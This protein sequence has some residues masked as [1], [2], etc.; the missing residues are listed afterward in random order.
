M[1][2]QEIK[3]TAEPEAIEAVSDV[4]YQLGS[5]G[6]VIED[7]ELL[8]KMASSGLWDACELS[9]D[10]FCQACPVVK[11]YFP[12]N[13]KLPAKIEE[14]KREITEIAARLGQK[15]GELTVAVVREEDWANSWKAYFKPVHIGRHFVIRPTWEP[16][17]ARKGDIVIDLDPGMAFGTGNHVTTVMCAGFLEKY[18]RPGFQVFDVGC[19][20]G[21][22][23]MFA[24]RL[25]AAPVLALDFDP[26]A[27]KVAQENIRLNRLQEHIRVRQNDLLT[28]VEGKADLIA[29][30]IIADIIIRLF[31]QVKQRLQPGGVFIAS[32]IIGGRKADVAQ[33]AGQLGFILAAEDEREDWVAQVWKLKGC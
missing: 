29:A 3:V 12:M 31:P 5:G 32:G 7:P 17:C 30:N 16:Y 13:E 15:P 28:G 8:K 4:F 14:L 23:A 20:T 18:C 26:V 9:P 25:G 33:A 11:G 19:G 21:I 10:S 24:A 2:W 1:D 27:V 6:V 22:L